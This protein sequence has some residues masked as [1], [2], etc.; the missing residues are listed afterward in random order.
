M[1]VTHDLSIL[2]LV[3]NASLLVQLVMALLLLHLVRQKVLA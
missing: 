2:S 3:T 1:N